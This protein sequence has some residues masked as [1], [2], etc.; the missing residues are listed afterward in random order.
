MKKEYDRHIIEKELIGSI[1]NK[2]KMNGA[3]EENCSIIKN[4]DIAD[5][6]GAIILDGVIE[7]SS[8]FFSSP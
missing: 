2:H 5:W 7:I 3:T 1:R 6:G 8:V 4:Y